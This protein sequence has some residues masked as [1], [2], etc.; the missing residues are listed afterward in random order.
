M[1]WNPVHDDLALG[2][3][4]DVV[5]IDPRD[6]KKYVVIYLVIKENSNLIFI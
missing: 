6:T 4:S 3:N 5:G 1:A 2:V